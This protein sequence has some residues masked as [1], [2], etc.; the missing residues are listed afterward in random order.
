[1]GIENDTLV[2]LPTALD[3]Q[4]ALRNILLTLVQ[5]LDLIVGLR[6]T[7]PSLSYSQVLRGVAYD[8]SE[9]SRVSLDLKALYDRVEALEVRL[10]PNRN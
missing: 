3:D 10:V 4:L 9:A 2:T 1:M 7:S 5:Q 8:Q 6:V